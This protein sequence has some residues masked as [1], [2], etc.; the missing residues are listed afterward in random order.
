MFAQH[1]QWGMHQH[2]IQVFQAEWGRWFNV[3]GLFYGLTLP[4]SPSEPAQL[5]SALW[6]STA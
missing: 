4:H 3:V 2:L 1:R 6:P 5:P